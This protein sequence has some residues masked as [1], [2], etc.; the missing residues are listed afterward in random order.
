MIIILGNLSM[1]HLVFEILLE[2]PN[3]SF[4]GVRLVSS[5]PLSNFSTENIEV[6]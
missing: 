6:I 5:V 4:I 1:K 3:S 2:K